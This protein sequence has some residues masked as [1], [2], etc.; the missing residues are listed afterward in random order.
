MTKP[1]FYDKLTDEE[2]KEYDESIKV[3]SKTKKESYVLKNFD[4]WKKFLQGDA[5][6]TDFARE[7]KTAT[8][9]HQYYFSRNGRSCFQ[10]KSF[11]ADMLEA[12]ALV[13]GLN[14][15]RKSMMKYELVKFLK[16]SRASKLRDVWAHP[17]GDKPQEQEPSIAEQLNQAAK[18]QKEEKKRQ[19]AV[20]QLNEVGKE[21]AISTEL[22]DLAKI[23][24]LK[25][26]AIT[27]RPSF[28]QM[29]K[30]LADVA[31][32]PDGKKYICPFDSS[33]KRSDQWL[34]ERPTID[35]DYVVFQA[36]YEEPV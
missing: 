26:K 24:E 27:N 9:E 3:A 6:T 1:S 32:T 33:D 12:I 34:M 25:K 17:M 4:L 29:G 16:G 36:D 13:D 15:Q 18:S 31:R 10:Y 35:P 22:N 30:S 28:E 20:L 8:S 7:S 11:V 23:Q 5:R 2:K 14:S 19:Q 21:K